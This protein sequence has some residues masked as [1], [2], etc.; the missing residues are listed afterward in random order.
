[1]SKSRGNG[2]GS[3]TCY[4]AANGKKKYRVRV[5]TGVYFDAENEKTKVISK[6]L[7]VFKTKAE[8]EAALAEYNSS[9]YD[10]DKKITTVG[11]L[12]NAW[13]KEYFE[14]ISP[15]AE[16]SVRAAWAYCDDISKLPLK[17]L[18][19]AHIEAVI[20]N[21]SRVVIKGD[22]KEIRK[23]SPSTQ[24]RIKSIF[25]L[26]LDY[27]VGYKILQSNVARTFD[28]KDIRK[29]ADYQKKIKEPFS[30]EELNIL[31]DNVEEYPF[32]DMILVGCYMGWR[33]SELCD[34]EIK[35][36][37]LDENYIQGGNKTEAGIDRKV[38]ISPIIRGF[39][40]KRYNQAL[41]LNS[42]W[43]FNDRFSQ[44][45]YHVTY[46]KY[47]HK[48][49]N[50]MRYLGINNKTG[51]CQRVTFVTKCYTA[52]IPEHIIKRLCGHSLKNNVTDYVYNYVTQEDLYQAVCSIEK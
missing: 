48:F 15:S 9:P 51:H 47:R 46:D 41:S 21:G 1:M 26:M 18:G 50:I 12:Y 11:E 5:T 25:N 38:P 7:G 8:A 22:K 43:L 17:K 20:R 29:Q 45:G 35:N 40:E 30:Q 14:K 28:V 37:H 39:I 6:S 31:W 36:V 3:V 16:R 42:K 24:A 13:S 32:I 44:T 10:L 34:L 2:A 23:A 4:L 27:A 49:E 19:K 33:P 52:K